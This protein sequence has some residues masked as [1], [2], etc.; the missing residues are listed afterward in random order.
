[1]WCFPMTNW[2]LLSLKV[3]KASGCAVGPLMVLTLDLIHMTPSPPLLA[4]CLFCRLCKCIGSC[5]SLSTGCLWCMSLRLAL[6]LGS[7]LVRFQSLYLLTPL[8]VFRHCCRSSVTASR[9]NSLM[10]CHLTEVWATPLNWNRAR[11]LCIVQ[12][13]P[14]ARYPR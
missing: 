10:A 5:S 13:V 8:S 12:C 9:Q 2:M 7:P 6:S 14:T 11:S 3:L 1:M 4:M